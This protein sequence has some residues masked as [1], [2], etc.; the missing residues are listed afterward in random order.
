MVTVQ[1]FVNEKSNNLRKPLTFAM[2]QASQGC[3]ARVAVRSVSQGF[4]GGAAAGKNHAVVS[5]RAKAGG[6]SQ[7]LGAVLGLRESW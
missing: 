1:K 5:S 7:W 6:K 4:G 2:L 3:L